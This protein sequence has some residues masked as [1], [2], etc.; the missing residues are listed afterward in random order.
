MKYWSERAKSLVPYVP[1]EQPKVEDL[2][3]LNTNESPYPPSDNVVCAMKQAVNGAL[4]LYPEPESTDLCAAAAARHGL[5]PSQVFIGNGSD[6][7]LALSFLAYSDHKVRFFDITYSFYPVYASLFGLKSEIIP[8]N[9]DFTLPLEKCCTNDGMLIFPNPNA[10]TS[11][12]IS[13]EQIRWLLINN[14]DCVVVVDEAYAEF[15]AESAIPLIAE[16]KNLLIVKT[17]S[18]SHSLAGLRI[19][20]AFGNAE[21]VQALYRVKN[22]FNSYPVDRVAQAGAKAALEDDTNVLPNI[23]KIIATRESTIKC[24]QTLGFDCLES[25]ANFIFTRHNRL[26]GEYLMAELRKRN[27]LVRRFNA[28]RTK[29]YI[30]ITVGTDDQMKKLA[31]AL[32]EMIK[33]KK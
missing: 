4:R 32:K 6:E 9:E 23:A 3:K 7:V 31:E 29:D 19:G 13:R 12:A 22:S 24:L 30:R 33:T 1:G 5:D 21:L 10:P 26:S 8:L 15:G 16:F 27:I 11:L 2:I 20:M 17:L 18:K 28:L 25:K 14:P